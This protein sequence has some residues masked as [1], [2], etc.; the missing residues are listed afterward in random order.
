MDLTGHATDFVVDTSF[1]D[2]MPRFVELSLRRWPGLYLCGR[3]FT[4]DDLAGWRLPE[5][6]DEYSAIVTFAAGQEMEDS[7][8]D[9]GYALDASGQGPYSVLYRSHPSPLSES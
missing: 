8:E 5:S 7:W 2:A 3:P 9:N 1:P 6:D 4:A